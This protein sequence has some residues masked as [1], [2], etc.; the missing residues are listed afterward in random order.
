MR[1]PVRVKDLSAKRE[2]SL[3]FF[4]NGEQSA[5]AAVGHPQ[6]TRSAQRL[7]Q[8]RP[9]SMHSRTGPGHNTQPHVLG[10]RVELKVDDTIYGTLHEKLGIFSTIF[11]QKHA[12]TTCPLKDCTITQNTNPK[13]KF[14]VCLRTLR[15]K[16]RF[17]A[18]P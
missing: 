17:H 10:R 15:G 16:E 1:P 8:R 11:A 6:S 3:S 12:S 5:L 13:S 7:C 18:L 2:S 4:Q 9:T 14:A